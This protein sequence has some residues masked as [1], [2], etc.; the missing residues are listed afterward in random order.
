MS[1]P[2]NSPMDRRTFLL[3]GASA[4]ALAAVPLPLVTGSVPAAPVTHADSFAAVGATGRQFD[5]REF[6]LSEYD[7]ITPSLGFSAEDAME[8]ER[9][10]ATARA[11]LVTST[12]VTPA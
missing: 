12:W 9:W 6:C 5:S 7:S 10:Q 4:G 1:E 2:L 3:R 11:R 8:A